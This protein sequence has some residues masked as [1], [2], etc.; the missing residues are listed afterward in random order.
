ML[1]ESMKEMPQPHYFVSL[2]I[3]T[4]NVKGPFSI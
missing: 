3:I 4:I 2:L 1:A